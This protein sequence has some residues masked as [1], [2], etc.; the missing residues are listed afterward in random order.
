MSFEDHF[1][2]QSDKY[3]RYRFGYPAALYKALSEL[4]P[5]NE[6]AV[7]VGC[8]NGQSTSGLVDS[9]KRVVACDASREQISQA[10]PVQSVQYVVARAEALPVHN[11]TAS[12]VG[13]AQAVHWFAL[14]DFYSEVKRVLKPGGIV[15]IWC[16]VLPEVEPGIDRVLKRLHTEIL[17]AYWSE[18][19]HVVEQRYRTLPFP[20]EELALPEFSAV[21][22]W[23]FASFKGYLESWSAT[24]KYRQENNVHPV[25]LVE[26]DFT[27]AWGDVH[28]AVTFTWPLYMRV[29]RYNPKG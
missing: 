3:A 25:E 5:D 1:S 6:L 21:T 13:C 7:D 9:F 17:G 27:A 28:R 4:C 10:T 29:G 14:A 22:S 19:T 24:Q 12:F 2:Q 20:F 16:Y 11:R 18:K 8:G 23:D 26:A 15:A